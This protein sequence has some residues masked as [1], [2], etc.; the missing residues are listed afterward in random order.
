LL[1][2]GVIDHIQRRFARILC[3]ERHQQTGNEILIQ[4]VAKSFL[5]A[6]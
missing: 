4:N 3:G 1:E 5:A 2:A 6:R